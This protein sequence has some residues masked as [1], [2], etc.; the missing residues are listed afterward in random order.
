MGH[1]ANDAKKRG[2]EVVSFDKSPNEMGL[3]SLPHL[4]GIPYV[5]GD[6]LRLHEY[7]RSDPPFDLAVSR[8]AVKWIVMPPVGLEA[9]G[10]IKDRFGQLF[11]EARQV[12]K[13]S[14]EF[15]FDSEDWTQAL[16]GGDRVFDESGAQRSLA[17][18]RS[19]DPHVA[20]GWGTAGGERVPFFVLKNE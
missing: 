14:G 10:G 2:I 12:L 5:I 9:L 20:M 7:F 17:F 18:L 4:T 1:F 8:R 13:P 16:H 19:I 6:A 11:S 3:A 15:R